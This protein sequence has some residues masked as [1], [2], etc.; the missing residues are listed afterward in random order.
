MKAIWNNTVI[1]ESNNTIEVEGNQYF[2]PE[3][4]NSEFFQLSDKHTV[5]SWKGRAF[6]FHLQVGEEK[7]ADAAWFYPHPKAE[8]EKIKNYV[9]FWNGVEVKE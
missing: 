5:C 8:A 6:Y 7:N 4:I 1:A 9:A 3:A 2:P